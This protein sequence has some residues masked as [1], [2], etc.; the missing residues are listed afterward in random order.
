M[1]YKSSTYPDTYPSNIILMA[2]SGVGEAAY[3]NR[4][5]ELDTDSI[6]EFYYNH[7][8]YIYKIDSFYYVN[9]IGEVSLDYDKSKKTITLI[10]CSELD[11]QLVYIGYLIDEI[12]Y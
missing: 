12:N 6:V 7:T 9:K 11:K 5:N 2:H 10:T 4:L 3:F 8:K 1:I